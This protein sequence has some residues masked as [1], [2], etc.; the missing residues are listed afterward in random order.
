M[1]TLGMADAVPNVFI[2]NGF[3][4]LCRTRAE[5]RANEPIYGN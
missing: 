1:K 5:A 4:K 2:L 3:G